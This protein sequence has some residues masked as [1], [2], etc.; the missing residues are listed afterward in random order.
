MSITDFNLNCSQI[1]DLK[2]AEQVNQFVMQPYIL[3]GLLGILAIFLLSWFIGGFSKIGNK[4][5]FDS[6]VHNRQLV[7]I[8]VVAIFILLW[9]VAGIGFM[10]G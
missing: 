9:F 2:P 4:R 7:A 10:R 6:W 5:G 8:L 3:T 1:V